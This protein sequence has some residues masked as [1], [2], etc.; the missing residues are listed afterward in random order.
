[1]KVDIAVV[2]A[3]P[4]G[5]CF[6]QALSGSGLSIALIEQESAAVLAQPPFDGREIALTHAS[7]RTLEQLDMWSRID[8]AAIAPLRD[9]QVFNGPSL[10]ALKISAG[11]AEGQLGYL[12]PN[13]LI[14]RAAFEAVQAHQSA[15][16]ITETRVRKLTHLADRVHLSLSNGEEVDAGLLIAADSRFSET[17]RLLGIGAQMRDFGRTMMVCRMTHEKP[18]H[19]VAWEWFGYGQTLALLPLNDQDGKPMSSVVLTLP[20]HTMNA[21][22]TLDDAAFNAE[23]TRRFSTR[24][25]PMN[26]LPQDPHKQHAPNAYPLI[27]VYANR[28]S[29]K[30]C[31]LIGDAAVGMHPVTAHGFNFGLQSA[32][33]LAANLRKTPN[34]ELRDQTLLNQAL[35]SYERAHRLAT[36][37]L[38]QSTN[39]VVSLYTNDTGPAKLLR[40]AA[41]HI[42]HYASPFKRAIAAHLTQ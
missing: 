33:R 34:L 1:M 32:Q 10:F 35:A 39:L 3:G 31:A 9:A 14:R 8:P 2:G 17:R 12:V 40:N 42:A 4:S 11:K 27:G 18:H 15:K 23:I 22:L 16:L 20:Q 5:L 26:K 28:F 37:P 41:L 7:K 30:R 13:H 24:L 36:L 38:Y 6:A 25:G 29:G 19:N 21:L